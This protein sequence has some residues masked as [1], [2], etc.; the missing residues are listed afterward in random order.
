MTQ[1]ASKAQPRFGS[2]EPPPGSQISDLSI[3]LA[4]RGEDRL[5]TGLVIVSA[6]V[7]LAVLLFEGFAFQREPVSLDDDAGIVADLVTD[8]EMGAK[9]SARPDTVK[10]EHS[11]RETMLPQLPKN[12][13]IV[14]PPPPDPPPPAEPQA[15]L[16]AVPPPMPEPGPQPE[17]P[18][19]EA[20]AE[21]PP[22]PEPPQDAP[23][24]PEPTLQTPDDDSANKL[25]KE[26]ALKRLMDEQARQ[27][28]KFAKEKQAENQ[29]ALALAAEELAKKGVGLG[30]KGGRSYS[31]YGQKLKK[32]VQPHYNI[33]EVY[34]MRASE[35]VVSI[36][37]EVSASGSLMGLEVEK[38]SGV[39]EFDE[40][41]L[42]AIRDAV[43]LPAPPPDLAGERI[44]V[45]FSP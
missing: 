16:K 31:G 9:E 35:Y 2:G 23:K 21:K 26:D 44:T 37:I 34:R 36:T 22:K 33:P 7:H 24:P 20:A 18:K 39:I 28:Q 5:F 8:I 27:E 42:K 6:F 32:A 1:A 12:F 14:Q 10:G 29:D 11:V 30:G 19:E 17:P 25:K 41:V 40:S 38:S 43:P 45:N 15:D 13:S 4:R 3:T